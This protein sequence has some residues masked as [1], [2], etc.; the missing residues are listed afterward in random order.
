MPQSDILDDTDTTLWSY[1]EMLE[2]DSLILYRNHK[3]SDPRQKYICKR[4]HNSL[5]EL[6]K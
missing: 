3:Y 2:I 6:C 1:T 4:S 5:W